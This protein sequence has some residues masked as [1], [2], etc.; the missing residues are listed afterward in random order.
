[1]AALRATTSLELAL[2][3]HAVAAPFAFAAV[4]V[5]YF[6]GPLAFA[7]LRT[8]ILF[9]VLSALFDL[10]ILASFV[11]GNLTMFTSF[12]RSWSP[13]FLIFVAT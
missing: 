3:V 10:V 13:L 8:A 5:S 2:V 4:T 9:A 12:A 1:M 11:E 7:P 6:R